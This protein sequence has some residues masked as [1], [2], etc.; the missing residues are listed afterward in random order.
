MVFY[1]FFVIELIIFPKFACNIT[2]VCNSK[3]VNCALK[4]K[5]YAM[6]PKNN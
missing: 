6:I 5:C 3:R 2:S 4:A 1:T